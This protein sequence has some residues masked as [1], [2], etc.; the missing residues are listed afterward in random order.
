MPA[1]SQIS[2]SNWLQSSYRVA[3]GNRTDPPLE[4]DVFSS[5]GSSTCRLVRLKQRLLQPWF[6]DCSRPWMAPFL[7]LVDVCSNNPAL[8]KRNNT[9]LQLCFQLSICTLLY[10]YVFMHIVF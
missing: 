8:F 1:H 10:N 4:A 5:L 3:S 7:S 9:S 6:C 2:F